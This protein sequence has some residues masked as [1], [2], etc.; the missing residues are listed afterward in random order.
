MRM[1]SF[2]RKETFTLIVLA[3]CLCFSLPVNAQSN[4]ELA[5]I[6]VVRAIVNGQDISKNSLDNKQCIQ[7]YNQGGEI[8]FANSFIKADSKSYGKISNV[9]YRSIREKDYS[10]SEIYSF[11]WNWKNT[12]DNETGTAD[13]YIKV[14]TGNEGKAARV[15]IVSG[16]L[17]NIL[18]YAGIISGSLDRIK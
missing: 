2:V 10:S 13:V 11:K 6:D 7:L 15:I 9:G 14:V 5:R 18:D 12:F 4:R 3:V 8:M 16:D 1:T 17:E